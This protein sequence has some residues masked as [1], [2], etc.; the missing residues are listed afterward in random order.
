MSLSK[1]HGILQ[2]VAFLI[3]FP[4]GGIIAIFRNQ[5]GGQWLKYHIFFQ[6]L[7]SILV[8]TAVGIQLY[9]RKNHMQNHSHISPKFYH[10]LIGIT[11]V[12]LLIFQIFWA[13]LGRRVVS[14]TIWYYIHV[15]LA[16]LIIIGGITNILVVSMDKTTYVIKPPQ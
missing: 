16:A 12:L 11:I 9:N 5:I 15:T 4:I 8:F 1:I 10:V 14:W 6:I 13:F 7:A 2:M 3:L